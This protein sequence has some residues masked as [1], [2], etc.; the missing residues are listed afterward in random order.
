MAMAGISPGSEHARHNRAGAIGER[1]FAARDDEP[2]GPP[3][4]SRMAAEGRR[5]RADATSEI[6]PHTPITG[7]K[8]TATPA[9]MPAVRHDCRHA[10]AIA[11]SS[12]TYANP[13]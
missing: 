6:T 4:A 10:A 1:Q 9:A 7:W 5:A 13:L 3:G 8:L 2:S 12:A 11:R